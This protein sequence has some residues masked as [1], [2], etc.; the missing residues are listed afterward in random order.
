MVSGLPVFNCFYWI[1]LWGLLSWILTKQSMDS[2]GKMMFKCIQSRACRDSKTILAYQPSWT[3]HEFSEIVNLR[4]R[5][6]MEVTVFTPFCLF[7]CLF[8]CVFV[9]LFVCEQYYGKTPRRISTKLGGAVRYGP[10]IMPLDFG[11]GPKSNMAAMAAILKKNSNFF[12][13]GA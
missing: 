8:V 3:I 13:K 6:R 7:V 11:L 10:R 12:S 9:C 5:R 1:I 4:H 2:S